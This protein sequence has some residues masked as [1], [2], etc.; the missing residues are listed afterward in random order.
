MWERLAHK[1][2]PRP[3]ET[4][5]SMENKSRHA[6]TIASLPGPE[7]KT[8][9]HMVA[10]SAQQRFIPLILQCFLFTYLIFFYLLNVYETSLVSCQ[11]YKH[12][13]IL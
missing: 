12:R 11:S 2:N 7:K 8:Q 6:V 4:G 5:S 1:I 9:Q 13:T 3:R 10:H